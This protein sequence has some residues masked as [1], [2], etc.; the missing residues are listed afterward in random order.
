MLRNYLKIALRSFA[1]QKLYTAINILGLAIGLACCL[2]IYFYVRNELSYDR[3]H[4]N[5]DRLYRVIVSESPPDRDPFTYPETPGP[6]A[7]AIEASLPEVERAVRIGLFGGLIRK[8]DVN[9]AERIHLTDPDFFAMFDFP[10]V[11]GDASTALQN[12]ESV[13]I[14][15]RLAGKYFGKSPAV[16]QSL[17]IKVGDEFAEYIVT[18]IAKNPPPNS[19]IRFDC[20]VPFDNVRKFL[21]ERALS[22]WFRVYFETYVALSRPVSPAELKPKLQT[23]VKN[24]YPPEDADIVTLNLQPITAIH[25]DTSIRPGFEPTSNP[26]YSYIL[27]GIALLVLGIACINFTTLSLGRLAGRTREV[28]IRKVLGAVRQQLVQQYWG[29]ALLMTFFALLLG[30]GL[31]AAFLPRFSALANKELLFSLDTGTILMLIGLLFV[32][33]LVAGSYPSLVLSR[34]H[35]ADAIKGETAVRGGRLFNRS[36]VVLQ[37]ALSIFLIISTLVMGKQ[38]RYLQTKDLGFN[39]EQVVVL[40]NRSPQNRSAQ[41]VARLRNALQNYP[42]V[43]GVSGSSNTYAMEWARMGFMDETNTFRQFYQQTVDYD[44][45]TTMEIELLEGRNFSPAFP[46]DSSQAIIVNQALVRY[47]G[48]EQPIGERLPGHR[49]RQH[50]VIGVVKDFHFQSLENEIAPLVLTLDPM[51]ILHGVSDVGLFAPPRSLNFINVRL[52]PGTIAE[53]LPLLERIWKEVAPGQPFDFTFLDR[54]V[55]QQYADEARWG[56]L[57]GVATGFAVL[58]ACMG[59]FGLATLTVAKKTKEIGIRKVVGASVR[60]ILIQLTGYFARLVLVANLFAWP[61]AYYAMKR[62]LQNFAYRVPISIEIFVLAAVAALLVALLTV[63]YQATRAALSNPV[64]A[65][66]NE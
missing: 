44:Y 42:Q 21:S 55:Q 13:V 63:S 53:A 2:L 1:W 64:E 37:F 30:L 15:E 12:T 18:G 5:A 4:R 65:I 27:I 19:S 39:Q 58:I 35:P 62:W 22:A 17:Q 60:D 41:V 34:I 33:G 54:D 40:R 8:G 31:A 6:M 51:T 26:T 49:F 46:T 11:V 36:L 38:L 47:F 56:T 7:A 52:R 57:V 14:T 24:H 29:E 45:L 25:L 10:L 23:V 61:S 66:R 43:L 28:G 16:G 3:F 50:Q 59:L 20:V 48:W 32:V 9:L